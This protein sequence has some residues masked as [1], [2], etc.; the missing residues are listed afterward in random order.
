ME[1]V[2]YYGE[3]EVRIGKSI[4]IGEDIWCLAYLSQ[5]KT[6]T[7]ISLIDLNTGKL[8][9]ETEGSEQGKEEEHD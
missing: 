5:L 3:G 9:E 8:K 1:Q 7:L 2:R 4:E 6:E